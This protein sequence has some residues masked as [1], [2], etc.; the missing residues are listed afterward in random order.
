M[1]CVLNLGQ[2]RRERRTAHTAN[3]APT[4]RAVLRLRAVSQRVRGLH[5]H[6]AAC[7]G[8][9][10]RRRAQP[11]AAAQLPGPHVAACAAAT[12]PARRPHR[13]VLPGVGMRL[14]GGPCFAVHSL[15]VPARP[16]GRD[17][18]HGGRAVHAAGSGAKN[19]AAAAAPPWL[20]RRDL[21]SSLSATCQPS[22]TRGC[23]LA[24]R[25]CGC[26]RAAGRRRLP[27]LRCACRIRCPAS[28]AC[29]IFT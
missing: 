22:E 25:R 7:V 3:V 10:A 14:A 28:A 23:P 29:S 1:R 26:V 24:C 16:L 12:P 19:A 17:N 21:A 2:A 27:P 20:R 5:G 15:S 8:F 6:W 9:V 13:R 18:A 11:R 4:Q